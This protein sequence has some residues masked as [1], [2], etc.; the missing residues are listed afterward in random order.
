MIKNAEGVSP[1][2]VSKILTRQ[3]PAP[4][5]PNVSLFECFACSPQNPPEAPWRTTSF[6]LKFPARI[7][8]APQ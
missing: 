1:P 2:H 6:M 7:C 3:F 4:K 5:E 8:N